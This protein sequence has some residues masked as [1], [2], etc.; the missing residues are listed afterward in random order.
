M[1]AIQSLLDELLDDWYYVRKGFIAEVK[2]IPP[3]R[4][5]FRPT[6]ESRTAMELVQHILELGIMTTEELTRDDTNLHRL[7]SEQLVTM[8]GKSIAQAD[9]KDALID[10]LVEQ[11]REGEN[12]CRQK[13]ELHFLQTVTLYGGKVRTRLSIMQ[14][15]I[16]HEMYHRGQLALSA[17]LLGL[18]PALT[19]ELRLGGAPGYPHGEGD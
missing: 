18:E 1:A 4:F 17:R 16:Q 19:R 11:Y 15:Y 9:T 12:L 2:N 13:G 14:A 3:A 8:Y 10:M 7:P 5:S 6:L